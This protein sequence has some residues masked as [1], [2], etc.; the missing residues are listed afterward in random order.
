MF[1]WVIG[2]GPKGQAI[3]L[4]TNVAIY[5]MQVPRQGASGDFLISFHRRIGANI[6]W[7]TSPDEMKWILAHYPEIA[8]KIGKLLVKIAPLVV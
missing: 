2:L 1:Q 6:G 4:G 8:Q 5:N 3:P 7:T